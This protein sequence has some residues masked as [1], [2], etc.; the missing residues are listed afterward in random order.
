MDKKKAVGLVCMYKF[1]TYVLLLTAATCSVGAS[2]L[3]LDSHLHYYPEHDQYLGIKEAPCVSGTQ[4]ITLE[5]GEIIESEIVCG[6]DEMRPYSEFVKSKDIKTAFLISPTF[7]I[8]AKNNLNNDQS[9]WTSNEAM[10]P[11]LDKRVSKLTQ[12]YRGR[13]IGLCGFNYSWETEIAKERIK[14][15]INLPGMKGL[16]IH[17]HAQDDKQLLDK[18]SAQE[19]VTQVLL[20]LKDKKAVVLW[21]L[22]ADISESCG[23]GDI[24]ACSQ[25][26]IGFLYQQA[27]KNSNLTF[28]V[29]HSMYE[30]SAIEV[31]MNLEKRDGVRLSNLYLET[32]ESAHDKLLSTW[33]SF[34]I[35]R[36]LY[37]SDNHLKDN[38]ALR[39]LESTFNEDEVEMI[40]KINASKVLNE[41]NAIS[42]R[43]EINSGDRGH[44]E[45]LG[46]SNSKSKISHSKRVQRR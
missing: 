43:Y 41:I 8:N 39:K 2:K 40:G 46:S 26:D 42:S 25:T 13:F 12:K 45:K 9:G 4:K 30:A 27:K 37:G 36:I 22:K 17:F 6:E 7:N 24:Q 5:S 35:D 23:K 33:R 18:S 20:G 19:T 29:A 3:V 16:K 28:I 15:C 10:I 14:Q 31:L 44:N 32:S 21:H 34:G 11:I 38:Y 1:F